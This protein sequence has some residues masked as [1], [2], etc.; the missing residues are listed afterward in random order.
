MAGL[1]AATSDAG[2]RRTVL[3]R[4]DGGVHCAAGFVP[5]DQ[6]QRRFEHLNGVFQ[7]GDHFVAGE[8]AC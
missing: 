4:F 6:D 2:Q 8:Q 1:M 7:A 5:K 3:D